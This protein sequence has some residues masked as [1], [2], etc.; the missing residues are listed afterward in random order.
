MLIPVQRWLSDVYCQGNLYGGMI[1][2][3]GAAAYR[4]D[5]PPPVVS[6]FVYLCPPNERVCTDV[7]LHS[8]AG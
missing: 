6:Q 7:R 1:G 2:M 5:M 3:M 4:A 8:Y